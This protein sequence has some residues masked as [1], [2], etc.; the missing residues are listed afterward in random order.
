MIMSVAWRAV[1]ILVIGVTSRALSLWNTLLIIEVMFHHSNVEL[2]RGIERW[3]GKIIVTPRM[4][5]IHHSVRRSEQDSNWSS[6]LT[7]WDWLH[8]TLRGDVAQDRIT[9]GVAE[10]RDPHQVTLPKLIVMP[11]A[12]I[13]DNKLLRAG[14]APTSAEP[15][16]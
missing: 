15:L 4:H 6:G 13:P 7:V 9:I 5:G 11:F 12:K 8:G 2:P 3:L 14:G 10:L 16:T 1:Q